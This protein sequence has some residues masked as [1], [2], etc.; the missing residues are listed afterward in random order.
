MRK[1]ILIF[2][3]F[4]TSQI[5]YAQSSS[6]EI[7]NQPNLSVRE[8]FLLMKSKSQSYQDYKVIKETV[9][10]G[11]VK[12]IQDSLQAKDAALRN[13]K[14]DVTRLKE[15]LNQVNIVLKQKEQSMTDIVYASTHITV[16]G[17]DFQKQSFLT[18]IVILFL[19][20]LLVVGFF[21]ARLK[22]FHSSMREKAELLEITTREYEEYKRKALEKQTKLSRELQDERNKLHR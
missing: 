13:V 17:I 8:R 6:S 5:A 14:A 15:E 22:M 11:V 2:F 7:L 18:L 19:A 16:L 1:T 3:C 12:I 20:L 21:S 9:L 10:D 4:I